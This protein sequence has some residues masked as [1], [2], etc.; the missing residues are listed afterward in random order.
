LLAPGDANAPIDPNLPFPF[1]LAHALTD[2]LDSLG[3]TSDWLIEWKWDGIRAQLIRR[4]CKTLL[5]SRG[6]E[7]VA[8]AFPEI[9]H[10]A[11]II[12][13]GT[14]I[15]GEI[16]AWEPGDTKPLPFTRLQ[17]R[18]NR[19]GVDLS[20]WPE[21]PVTFAA[22]DLL[23]SDGKDLRHL[24]L[25][26][27]RKMLDQLLEWDK[28][29]PDLRFSLPQDWC[30][31]K[32]AEE[33]MSHSRELGVEGVMLKRLDSTYKA[34][35]PTGL[36][37]KLK[38]QPYTVD[39]VMIAAQ[40]G[41]GRRAGLLTDYTFAVWD[42]GQLVPVAKAYSG[43]TD[44]E[45]SEVDRFARTH[46]LARHGPVHSVEPTRVFEIGFEAIQEST[47]HKSGVA[48][49]FPRILRIRDDKKAEEADQLET[50]RLLLKE[51]G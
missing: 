17:R 23:E 37:W 39:A 45:I 19:Q 10:A 25:V 22:F 4:A 36:W 6:D 51:R 32:Q 12:P 8:S 7:M 28:A 34:G 5:W 47:R 24:P 16:L 1:M 29:K 14:V 21:V 50:L 43:L 20:F 42:A 27:R 33:A 30:D 2:P 49:R 18:L 44:K 46:T 48:L 11:H 15:D 26:D 35:R 41:H 3:P 38:V 40:S 9:I 13:E 31:W